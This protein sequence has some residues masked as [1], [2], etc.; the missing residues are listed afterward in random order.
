MSGIAGIIG[1][2]H[3]SVGSGD[4]EQMLAAMPYRGVDG[5]G[6]WVQGN[7]EL[8]NA[9]LHTTPESV[10]EQ[11][12][13]V[14]PGKHESDAAL[15][16]VADARIDNRAE[17]VAALDIEV[18]GH[19]ILTDSEL[20]AQ[21]YERWGQ[22]CVDYLVGDFAFALWDEQREELFCARDHFGIKP[23][24][25]YQ[26][27][28]GALLFA[29]EIKALLAAGVPANVCEDRLAAYAGRLRDDGISTIYTGIVRLPAAHTLVASRKGVVVRRY[30]EVAATEGLEDISE[31]E[32]I[33]R[34]R[35]L[36]EEAVRCRT[37]SAFPVG[38]ELSG[39]LDSSFVACVA[40]DILVEDG[41]DPLHT[42]SVVFDEI[43]ES[44][45]RSYMQL[46]L[47]Q[48]HTRPHWIAGDRVGPLTDL[49]EIYSVLDDGLVSNNH[50]II[51]ALHKKAHEAGVRVILDGVDGDTTVSHGQLYLLELAQADEWGEWK[52]QVDAA[53][54]RYHNADHQQPMDRLLAS[55]QAL[56][57]S[58][59][60]RVLEEYADRGQFRRFLKAA[61]GIARHVG[62]SRR[63]LLKRFW[64]KLLVPH[65]LL[66]WRRRRLTREAKSA[67]WVNTRFA[68]RTGLEARFASDARSRVRPTSVR[69]GQLMSLRSPT[70]SLV[71]EIMNV[72][73]AY[74]HLEIRHPFLDK[75]LVEFCVG[76][77]SRLKLQGGWTRYVMRKAMEDVTPAPIT[78]RIGKGNMG[79]AFS[80]GLLSVD[81]RLVD[82][83]ADE[84]KRA[85]DVIDLAFLEDLYRRRDSLTFS[86][87]VQ[88][89]DLLTLSFWLNRLRKQ[90]VGR[91]QGGTTTFRSLQDEPAT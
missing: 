14:R 6:S 29:S 66:Q 51:W 56:F 57:K 18:D 71:H 74:H 28:G 76:L 73:A 25:Y 60:L 69:H 35:E 30:Y 68:K 84:A 83:Y 42:F 39:G 75:R 15:V 12:P 58:Y 45:E 8:G 16:L 52:V 89:A 2:R 19:S 1:N 79:P 34:F 70:W 87:Q 26:D 9:M 40:R 44:D 3:R 32:A 22:D 10:Y 82:R 88:F 55:P 64:K 36:F 20:I 65:G 5:H 77:P 72:R 61:G 63:R 54:R 7:V 31:S 13:L 67:P 43:N 62:P 23:F 27:A 81:A 78:W 86:E 17:L 37:R 59:G 21:A 80:H 50:Q 85:S 91:G 48:G 11:L 24:Y 46:V 33:T 4:V 38:S 53:A 41:R 90:N 47:D 49:E